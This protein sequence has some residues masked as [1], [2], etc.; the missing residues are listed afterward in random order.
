MRFLLTLCLFL[1]MTGRATSEILELAEG[2][3]T[4]WKLE[5]LTQSSQVDEF[6]FTLNQLELEHGVA[7]LRINLANGGRAAAPG[8]PDLPALSHLLYCAEG[9]VPQV[10][11]LDAEYEI[12]SG[13]IPRP[14][15]LP[16]SD[17]PGTTRE[18]VKAVDHPGFWP[19]SSVRIAEPV[20]W[21]GHRM[22]ALD[23]FPVAFDAASEE[24]RVLRSARI[25]VT[26]SN[27]GET[28][29]PRTSQASLDA[30]RTLSSLAINTND[31]ERALLDLESN[32]SVGGLL[33]VSPAA[34]M[35]QMGELLEW[36]RAQGWSVRVLYLE[37]IG[38]SF[39]SI[40]AAI[41]GAWEEESFDC[42]L[43]AGDIDRYPSG[44]ETDFNLDTGF[45]PGGQYAETVWSG[46]CNS[47]YCIVTDHLY[48]LLEGD[49][50]FADVLVGRLSVDTANQA[51]LASNRTVRYE[52]DPFTDL[53][54][55]WFQKGLMVY[56][57]A[58]AFSRREL[59]LAIREDLLN[60]LDFSQVDTVHNDYYNDPVSPNLVSNS[61]NN[62]VS[63]VNYRG[64][65]FRTQWAGPSFGVTHALS[66]QNVGR[67]PLVTSIVCGGGDFA[68]VDA[69]PCFGEAWL[70]SGSNPEEP[71]G[72][73][74]FIAPSEEDT[75][76]EWNN[77]IDAGIYQGLVHEGLRSMGSLMDRGKLELW[78]CYP[79]DRNWGTPGY[80]VPF[81]FHAYNLLGDPALRVR[82]EEPLDLVCSLP[83][84]LSPGPL[85]LELIVND[86]W[87]AYLEGIHAALSTADGSICI[88]AI[89]D[90]SGR[91]RLE[92]ELP[93]AAELNLCLHAD[94]YK[95]LLE[96]PVLLSQDSRLTLAGWTLDDGD[97]NLPSPGESFEFWPSLLE[98]GVTG[99]TD[100]VQLEVVSHDERVSIQPDM[101]SLDPPAPGETATTEAPFTI[102]LGN[103]LS[104]E[105]EIELDLLLDGEWI[106]CARMNVLH[107]SLVVH[108]SSAGGS[109]LPGFADTL[110]FRVEG[111][112][113][114]TD[115]LLA[116]LIS[117]DGRVT[118]SD[119][120]SEPIVIADGVS[121]DLGLF[122]LAISDAMPVGTVIPFR[123]DLRHAAD[124]EG[125]VFI[126]VPFQLS[127]GTPGPLDPLG[128]DAGGYMAYHSGDNHEL[129]PVH[130]FQSIASTGNE[131]QLCDYVT[132]W[133]NQGPDGQ[134]TTIDL[135]FSFQYYGEAYDRLT[136]CTNGWVSFGE[137]ELYHTAV[138]TP[139]PGA[140]GPPAMIAAYWTD[141]YNCTSQWNLI[142]PIY[143]Q[144]SI[145]SGEFIIEW[146]SFQPVGN[147][148]AITAQLI[149]RDPLIWE[150]GNGNGEILL[151]LPNV[152]TWN[153]TN[154]VTIGIENAEETA[155]MQIAFNELFDAAGQSVE[156]GTSILFR[157]MELDHDVDESV[158]PEDFVLMKVAPN[159]FNP[160]TQIELVLGQSGRVKLDVFDLSG[161]L[162]SSLADRR[163]SAGRHAFAFDGA[164]L[165]SGLYL[166]QLKSDTGSQCQKITL[167][168]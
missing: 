41:Q 163:I 138:N 79:N 96:S 142:S 82:V 44:T 5:A 40:Q 80:N 13:I 57:V 17:R 113:R 130:D 51:L 121:Q 92:G 3:D 35:E 60:G 18:E 99:L 28:A 162:V 91:I 22:A 48:S 107:S 115:E 73:I 85:A 61:V 119:E 148:Y 12:L 153:G 47:Q 97:D 143:T 133:W 135:P 157:P 45:I 87:G 69:D 83:T 122:E 49:D 100:A 111:L 30:L 67:W 167:L 128:P 105:E 43:L 59:K 6:A 145:E 2:S 53:G 24:L 106:G 38:N 58:L 63:M 141:L 102:F 159:P 16:Q 68:S 140:Q 126:R 152:T 101:L 156:D 134:T 89:S 151:H 52:R 103:S 14:A 149:L 146:N 84:T 120:T 7:G 54:P 71:A 112:G 77:A 93:P 26:W 158:K 160:V 123:L 74:G 155:G 81:Y 94:G 1:L 117:I 70:R 118:I 125:P 21:L 161:R 168:K 114:D 42:L 147:P 166:V 76:T 124:P 55:D 136:V 164:G 50:Y 56:D 39:A 32:V 27:S 11:L 78:L 10:E 75:H 88:T 31:V 139:I 23:L 36:R 64:F 66:L 108:S 19:K 34:A 104:H 127:A 109:F 137:H 116:T 8:E 46:R 33:I 9:R 129:A 154:G 150:T 37:D 20:V 15:P 144:Y 98:S 110:S 25:R 29:R 165:P 4:G 86:S 62:G 65:G 131:L 95:P 90:A 132:D 72:A